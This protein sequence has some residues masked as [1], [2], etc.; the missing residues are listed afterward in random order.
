MDREQNL[1]DK[2][3][4][5]CKEK[6]VNQET[7]RLTKEPLSDKQKEIQKE[8]TGIIN[9]FLT[10]IP[11]Q[12]SRLCFEGIFGEFLEEIKR[13]YPKEIWEMKSEKT[14]ESQQKKK[15]S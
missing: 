8:Y 15:V 7:F 5:I 10:G 9:V 13:K 12:N 11:V 2:M 6:E 4:K 14:K 1:L 3:S